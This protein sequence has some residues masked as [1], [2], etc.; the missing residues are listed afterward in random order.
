M[1]RCRERAQ[2]F[3]AVNAQ[4]EELLR[5]RGE[6]IRELEMEITESGRRV[7]EEQVRGAVLCVVAVPGV[8]D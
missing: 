3:E 1:D 6:R 2:H 5:Q 7:E 8:L 4:K